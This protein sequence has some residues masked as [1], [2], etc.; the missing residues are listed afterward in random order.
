MANMRETVAWVQRQ[1]VF[2]ERPL[3]EVADEFNRYGG[4]PIEISS[5]K[6]R[7]LP[8]SGVFNAYDTESFLA[9]LSRLDDVAV[10]KTKGR[11]EVSTRSDLS[12]K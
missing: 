4:T 1:I 11:I 3:S 12:S 10:S 7:S 6:I 5:E 9:F 8:I 2:E